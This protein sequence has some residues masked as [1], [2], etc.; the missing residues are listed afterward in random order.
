MI[1]AVSRTLARSHAYAALRRDGGGEDWSRE[2]THRAAARF[3]IMRQ[4]FRRAMSKEEKPARDRRITAGH[5]AAMCCGHTRYFLVVELAR[6]IPDDVGG[7]GGGD[8]DG[9]G[10]G[11]GGEGDDVKEKKK[12]K[13]KKEVVGKFGVADLPLFEAALGLSGFDEDF[14][15]K[16]RFSRRCFFSFFPPPLLPSLLFSSFSTLT[17]THAHILLFSTFSR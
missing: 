1:E 8:G 15:A 2:R 7:G 16:V 10:D 9:D 12:K 4:A 17:H 11:G 13:S 14:E 5:D 6:L 3:P